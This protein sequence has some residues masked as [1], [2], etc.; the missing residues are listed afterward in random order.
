MR[1]HNGLVLAIVIVMLWGGMM[2]I[3]VLATNREQKFKKEAVE[4]GYA[5]HNYATGEWE[6]IK[7]K[8]E[9]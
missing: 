5:M 9:K 6:W 8:I 4:L 2:L 7:P 3:G 1:D